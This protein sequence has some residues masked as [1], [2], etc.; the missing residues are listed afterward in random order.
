MVVWKL[1]ASGPNGS[2]NQPSLLHA[3]HYT[4]H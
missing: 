2:L 4:K 1:Y 3:T